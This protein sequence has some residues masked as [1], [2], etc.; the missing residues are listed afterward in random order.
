MDNIVSIV[1]VDYPY[2]QTLGI[3]SFQ[4]RCIFAKNF[5]FLS[6]ITSFTVNI[7]K[8]SENLMLLCVVSRG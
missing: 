1:I 2:V 7:V 6:S 3:K 8:R 4:I 5:L